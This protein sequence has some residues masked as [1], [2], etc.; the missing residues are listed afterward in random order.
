MRLDSPVCSPCAEEV[1]GVGSYCCDTQWDSICLDELNQ[2][3]R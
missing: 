3:C 1:C 2:L